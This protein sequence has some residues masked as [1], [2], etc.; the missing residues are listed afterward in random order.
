ME[1]AFRVGTRMAMLYQGKIIQD[2][3]PE[4]FKVSTNP[5]VRQFVTGEVEGPITE[6]ITNHADHSQ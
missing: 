6:G 3:T 4:S 2:G 5:V 1:S